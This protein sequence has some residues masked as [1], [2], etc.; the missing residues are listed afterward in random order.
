MLLMVG[1]G[2]PGPEYAGHRHNI[3]FMALDAI[4]HAYSFGPWRSKFSS[5]VSEGQI[6]TTKVLLQKPETFM[7]RS[8]LAVSRAA[9]FYK[10]TLDDVLVL[11]DELDLAPGRVRV[12][13]GGGVAG[14]N[15]LRSIAQSIGTRDF[16]RVR[17]GIGHPG[18]K[19]K[20]TGHVLGNFAKADKAWLSPL[21]DAFVS[22]VPFLV[23][24][25]DGG[26]LNKIA[27]LTK[28]NQHKT[29]S[30]SAD[31]AHRPAPAKTGDRG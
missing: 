27:A 24:R 11:H 7:N 21:L 4:T 17:F 16:K 15:G 23:D 9:H 10:L 1:L 19:A 20:V 28:P 31:S 5:Q 26:F 30:A 29:A 2:N 12:K 25:D 3:G 6:G 22:A 14:H 8:G 13:D 18:D